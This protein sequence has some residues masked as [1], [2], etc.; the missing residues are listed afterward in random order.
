LDTR[1]FALKLAGPWAKL[2]WLIKRRAKLNNIFF[3]RS[4][5]TKTT[6]AIYLKTGAFY[7]FLFKNFDISLRK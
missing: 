6:G 1:D 2:I 3:I 7:S 4:Y 5:K